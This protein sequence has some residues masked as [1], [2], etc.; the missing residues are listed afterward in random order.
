MSFIWNV[1]NAAINSL[2][3]I[4]FLVFITETEY[5]YCAV[6][7]QYLNVNQINLHLKNDRVMTKAVGCRPVTASIPYQSLCC[8]RL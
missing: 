8:M 6:R 3:N 7:N 2:K 1:Q 4:N 5:V